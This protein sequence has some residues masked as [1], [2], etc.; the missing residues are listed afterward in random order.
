M[1]S[2]SHS[3]SEECFSH[4][5]TVQISHGFVGK[6]SDALEFQ[7]RLCIISTC[8]GRVVLLVNGRTKYIQVAP[9]ED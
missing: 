8:I 3:G 5:V 2:C 9:S 1:K 7:K 4:E 6:N